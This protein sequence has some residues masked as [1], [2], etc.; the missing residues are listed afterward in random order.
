M[1]NP[2]FE[3][4]G[5]MAVLHYLINRGMLSLNGAFFDIGANVG[6]WTKLVRQF[7]DNLEVH[8]FEPVPYIFSK[9]AENLVGSIKIE[10]VYLNNYAMSLEEGFKTFHYYETQPPLSSFYRRNSQV[11]KKCKLSPPKP[12]SIYS[13]T[14][15][16]YCHRLNLKRISFMKIDVEGAE[17][18]V[19]RGA[20]KLLENDGIDYI[21]FE[22][23][24]TYL[25]AGIKL[26]QVFAYLHGFD[27][28][29]FKIFPNELRYQPQFSPELEDFNY[30]NYLAVNP[31]FHSQILNE[32]PKMLDLNQ[33]CKQHSIVPRGIIHIGAHEG[34]ETEK[35]L[36]MGAKKI[37]F[38]E[39]NPA[40]FE[41]L[42]KNT[43]DFPEVL[44]VNCA[45]SDRCG[46]MTLHITSMDQSSSLLP[47]K[48]HQ[49]Y[50]PDIKETHKISVTAKTLDTL[51]RE[52]NLS[53]DDYN[54]LNIDIQGAELLAFQGAVKTLPYIDCIN[55]EINY[56]ELYEGCAI[57]DQ[58]DTCL[59]KYGFNRVKTTTPY[60]HSWGDAF[61]VKKP[62]VTMATLGNPRYGRFANQLFQYAF[63]KIY[64]K[65][66]GFRVETANWIGN[67]L[68]G[69][70][71]PPVTKQLPLIRQDTYKLA[72]DHIPNAKVPY[73]NVD[74]GGIF[75]Y[76]TSFYAPHKEYFRSLFKP[77]P[78]IEKYLSYGYNKLKE[79]GNTIVG[80]HL[81]RGDYG[82]SH[83][84][85]A[86]TIWY[87]RWLEGYWETLD[88]PVLFIASD[89]PDKVLGDFEKFSPVTS[90]DLGLKIH[91]IEYYPDFYMLSQCDI[92]AISNSSFSFAASM[93]NE[94]AKCFFRPHLPTQKL[95]PFD[96]WHSETIFREAK[97][98]DY[99]ENE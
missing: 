47:L 69:I 7:K 38:I 25:D 61:Y 26:Q 39:A 94:K 40:V 80:L 21:Q 96:P 97:Q 15:D 71:D 36:E 27:F 87:L 78:V 16:A 70:S 57:V 9:L 77:V 2:S 45:I 62:V 4:T 53:T 48:H 63:I 8:V 23:G 85:R 64:A 51:L 12:F 66:H 95:I 83:Y 75:R 90:W 50:Y 93:L 92:L 55:T 10:P 67:I 65:T 72:E 35:Y 84:F 89:E 34:T 49:D 81:R 91:K 24:G 43:A 19:L 32:K 18:D 73:K 33:L 41:R 86:P 20:K 17:L 5:E 68:F 52:L 1:G 28:M 58:I 56:E 37:L 11:E 54:I 14:V 30:S 6:D 98:E 74:F 60:H 44:A 59:E 79:R 42:Q 76:H 88:H 22:Y 46:K 99:P 82:Y 31:R 3:S 29:I 13:T